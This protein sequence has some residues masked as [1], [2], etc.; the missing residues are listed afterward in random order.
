MSF[1][2][3]AIALLIAVTVHEF[4]HAAA[5]DYL[6]DPTARLAGRKT[7]N[8]LAHLDIFGTLSLLIFHIGWGKPV[9]VDPYNLRDPRRDSALISL[10]GPGSNLILATILALIVKVLNLPVLTI[11]YAIV[12]S[13]IIL[14]VSLA[15]FNLLPIHP[16]DGFKI[17]LGFL[18][19]KRAYE[20]KQLESYGLLFLL[21]IL[22]LVPKTLAL[23]IFPLINLILTFLLGH[24]L[25]QGIF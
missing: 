22:F 16:L 20:W 12:Q 4:S 5:A 24:N 9:P 13:A 21:G 23:T 14:N 2:P 6:G 15:I 19:E 17:V 8:P 3:W 1:I 10:A 18:P 11:F 7:L 25:G